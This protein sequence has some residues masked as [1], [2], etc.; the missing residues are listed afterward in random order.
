MWAA[1]DTS[2][3][4]LHAYDATTLQEL[5][6]SNQAPAS[7]DHFGTG[8]KFITPTIAHGKVYVPTTTGV[9]VFGLLKIAVP[10]VGGMTKTAAVTALSSA[11][12]LLGTV[13]AA[14]SS[15]V[16]AGSVISETPAAG[17]VVSPGS[18]VNLVISG[19][20]VV[21]VGPSS[22]SGALQTFTANFA[23]A[24][25]YQDLQWVQMLFAVATNGGGQAYCYV[26]YDA[27]GNRFWLY[28][29]ALGFFAGPIAPGVSS[30]LLQGSLCALNTSGSSVTGSWA[31]LTVNANVVFKQAKA[32][33][34]Y[35]RAY[36]LEGV[37]SGWV[38]QGTWTTAAASPGTM[39]VAP[40]SGSVTNGTQQTFTLTYPDTPGFAGAAFG[41]EQFLVGVASDGGGQPFCFV[42]YDRGGNGLWMYS[43]DVGFFLGPVTP[44]TSSTLLASSACSVNTAGATVQNTGGNLAV[45][46]PVTL[47][48]PTVG[49][50]KLF[51]RARTV[52]NVDTGFVQTGT[53]SVN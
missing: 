22:G 50:Q 12:L 44:G 43:N 9:G 46:V 4:V 25:G 16:P 27:Q 32:L 26:H 13:T 1:E 49:S 8:N 42:H 51:E 24:N 23:G 28:S 35:L 20:A 47:K 5:Y 30:N 31:D 29:D 39:T 11:G 33:N 41:W 40:S 2:P 21:S 53:L 37:D 6:N 38:Q 3:G 45:A 7:R 48:S 10:D 15:S 18:A 17:T 34:I 14:V 52:L 19:V 36:T